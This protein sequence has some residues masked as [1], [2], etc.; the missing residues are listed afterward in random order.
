MIM[1]KMKNEDVLVRL[2]VQEDIPQI[3]AVHI[4]NWREVT[5][6]LSQKGVWKPICLAKG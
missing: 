6:E 2:G 3:A 5:R 4:Q 1:L